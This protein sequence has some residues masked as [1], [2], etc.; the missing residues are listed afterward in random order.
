MHASREYTRNG[1]WLHVIGD[2]V[3]RVYLGNNVQRRSIK[4]KQEFPLVFKALFYEIQDQWIPVY[5]TI[6]KAEWEKSGWLVMS[7]VLS[8]QDSGAINIITRSSEI[9]RPLQYSA[10]PWRLDVRPKRD[11]AAGWWIDSFCA[12][13]LIAMIAGYCVKLGEI[14]YKL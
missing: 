6:G 8:S 14:I 3:P 10:Y 1:A 7:A 2:K 9:S 11:Q 5:I 4:R 12:R 13:I